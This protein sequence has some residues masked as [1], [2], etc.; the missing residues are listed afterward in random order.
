VVVGWWVGGSEMYKGS[1][2][3]GEGESVGVEVKNAAGC[4]VGKKDLF[5]FGAVVEGGILY[6]DSVRETF[7]DNVCTEGRR[8]V[9][10][11]RT[12]SGVD[13]G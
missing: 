13:T 2:G 8:L 11:K 3:E 4:D 1:E 6:E 12:E 9:G 10:T 5:V 7:G